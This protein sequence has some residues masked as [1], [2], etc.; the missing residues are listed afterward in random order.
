MKKDREKLRAFRQ[1]H[2]DYVEGIR[3]S[4]PL[5]DTL[6]DATRSAALRWIESL[7][8]A[9]GLR[10]RESRPSIAELFALA[11][12]SAGGRQYDELAASIETALTP[13][14]S[15]IR[16]ALEVSMRLGDRET[17]ENRQSGSARTTCGPRSPK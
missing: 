10:P 13:E 14:D 7:D 1:E 5:T 8:A 2:L 9:R 3:D 17:G 12:E 16:E 6:D 4:P 15:S 11:E